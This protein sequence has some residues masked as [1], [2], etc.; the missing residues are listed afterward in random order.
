MTDDWLSAET[1]TFNFNFVW[2]EPVALKMPHVEIEARLDRFARSGLLWF[3]S[4]T[5]NTGPVS[6]IPSVP[7]D[8]PLLF[9]QVVFEGG[10]GMTLPDIGR[11]EITADH[12]I[13]LRRSRE[14]YIV[15]DMEKPQS[16]HTFGVDA[17]PE[18]LA[19]WFG[20]RLPEELRPL[21]SDRIDRSIDLPVRDGHL[22]KAMA[23][24]LHDYDEPMRTIASEAL[25]MQMMSM[26]LHG[27]CG[28]SPSGSSFSAREVRA[29]KDARERLLTDLRTP[30]SVSELATLA[31]MTERRLDQAFRE[32]FGDSIFRTLANARLDHAY[33]ALIKGGVSVKEL[34]FRLGYTHASSFS[35]AFRARFGIYPTRLEK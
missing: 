14:G 2:N 27:L 20:G 4:R 25:A 30:P 31:G 22:I 26:F 35:H 9:M 34:A 21:L 6:M 32:L 12:P 3:E 33:R 19:D 24:Q 13:M 28:R 18:T 17:T 8:E 5:V 11:Q 15:L 29:A 23:A 10:A 16:A 7:T 1:G